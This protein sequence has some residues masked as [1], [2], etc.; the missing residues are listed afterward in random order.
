MLEIKVL[1]W[2]MHIYVVKAVI[3]IPNPPFLVTNGNTYINN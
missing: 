3:G 2:S 1:A